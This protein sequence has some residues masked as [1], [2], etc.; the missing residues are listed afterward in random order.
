M[1]VHSAPA[2]TSDAVYAVRLVGP[3][4]KD[5]RGDLVTNCRSTTP[6]LARRLNGKMAL[7]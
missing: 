7:W 3:S 4:Q 1:E 5:R 6:T 2:F